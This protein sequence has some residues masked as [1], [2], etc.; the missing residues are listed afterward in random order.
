MKSLLG[1]VGRNGVNRYED[2][3]AVQRLL[4]AAGAGIDEDGRCGPGTISAIQAYQHNWS[5]QPDGVVD[6][7]G[8]TWSR[9]VEG[10]LKVAKHA[11]AQAFVLLPQ[12]RSDGYYSYSPV[13][14]QYGTPATVKTLVSVCKKFALKYPGVSVAIGDMSFTDGASMS[15]HKSHRSGRDADIRPVRTDGKM[16]PVTYT[17]SNYSRERTAALVALLQ[18]ERNVKSIL[19]N[20]SHIVGVKHWAGHDNHLH[21][22]MK[23]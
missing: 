23:E 20:D 4:N 22:S 1:S 3:L 17:D 11:A 6:P 18:A 13:Q 9:L 16:L 2:V 8:R 19:F 12:V 5:Q 10:K 7:G 15:P 21:V 14:R